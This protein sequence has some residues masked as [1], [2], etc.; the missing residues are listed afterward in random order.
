MLQTAYANGAS[1]AFLEMIGVPPVCVITDVKQLRQTVRT[2]PM[3]AQTR[4]PKH[5]PP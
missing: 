3:R 5:P 4:P 2:A 1:T